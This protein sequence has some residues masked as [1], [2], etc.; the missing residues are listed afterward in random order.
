MAFA[1]LVVESSAHTF[2]ERGGLDNKLTTMDENKR[3]RTLVCG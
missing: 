1:R 3:Q 2:S